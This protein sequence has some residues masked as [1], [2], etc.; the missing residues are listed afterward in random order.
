MKTIQYEDTTV[1]KIINIFTCLDP[2]FILTYC[3]DEGATFVWQNIVE[4]G[5]LIARR[6]EQEIA[7]SLIQSSESTEPSQQ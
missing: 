4:E 2:R 5:K 3:A 6:L 7:P 1:K